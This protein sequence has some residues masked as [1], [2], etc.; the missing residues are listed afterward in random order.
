MTRNVRQDFQNLEQFVRQYRIADPADNPAYRNLLSRQHKVYHAIL[1]LLAELDHQSWFPITQTDPRAANVNGLF[2]ERL[3]EFASDLG[4]A[5]FSWLHGTYKGA[6]LLLRSS[7]EN[8]IKTIGLLDFDRIL[9]MRNTYEVFDLAKTGSFFSIPV[10]IP[11][12]QCLQ[13]AYSTLSRDVHTATSAEM[14]HVAAL[15]FFPRFGEDDAH[16]FAS[17][18]TRVASVFLEALVVLCENVY[19]AMHHGNRDVINGV[20]SHAVRATLNQ[21]ERP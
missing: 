13:D 10:N 8:F 11:R 6:R 16:R 14:Q 19:H 20:L 21:S 3:L 15:N 1:T 18:F 12:F 2:R 5:L 9:T 4:S 7:I 17:L